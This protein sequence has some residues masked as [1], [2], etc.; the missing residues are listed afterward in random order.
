MKS[1]Q[2]RLVQFKCDICGATA[3]EYA[4]IGMLIGVALIGSIFTFGGDLFEIFTRA[5]NEI[6]NN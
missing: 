1:M 5:G 4:L 3:V 6:A 2:R